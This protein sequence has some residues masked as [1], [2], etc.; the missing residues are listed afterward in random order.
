MTLQ[1]KLKN[2]LNKQ[3]VFLFIFLFIGFVVLPFL[4]KK[5]PVK[6]FISQDVSLPYHLWVSLPYLKEPYVEF[7]V[8]FDNPYFKKD[9]DYLIKRLACDE[10]HYLKVDKNKNYYCDGKYLGT[11]VDTDKDG[12]P[13]KNFVWDG[14]IPRG[15]CFVIGTH[16]RS[17][18]S[19]YFGFVD[20]DKIVRYLY[21]LRW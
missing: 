10:G 2:L 1:R 21:P 15:K 20:K 18:D 5:S 8:Y 19:R 16:K 3:L 13:V 11:A 14:P 4:Y 7:P 6:V 17:Y 9:R 12:N